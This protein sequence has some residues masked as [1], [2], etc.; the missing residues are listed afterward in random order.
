VADRPEFQRRQYAFAAHIR[1]PDAHPAPQVEDRRM[2]IY[3][4]LFFNNLHNL[5]SSTFPVLRKLHKPEKWRRMVRQFMSQH[6]AHT[7]YFLEIPREFLEFLQNAYV[8]E[9][10]DFPFLLELAHYE[11][12]ELALSVAT[13]GND[14]S[15]VDPGG[16]LLD[17]VPVLSVLAWPLSYEF[18]VHRISPD[19][20][21]AAPGD[22]PTCLV[23][24]RHADDELGFME[25]NA[26][27]AKLLDRID[28]NENGLTG[29]Q[30]LLALADEIAYAD[31]EALVEHGLH[32]MED[33]RRSGILLGVSR[34]G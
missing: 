11:W 14:L 23:V 34:L 20:T 33:M 6:R 26:V 28:N 17:G 29:R 15:T 25:L 10:D 19:F 18:P 7:P 4:D 27:T 5:L 8:R 12:T 24:Y 32:A 2:A 21:P 9:D 31:K 22:A 16:D 3:R 13:E 30:L 1:D